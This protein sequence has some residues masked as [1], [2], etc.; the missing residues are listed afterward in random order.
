LLN[1]SQCQYDAFQAFLFTTELLGTLGVVPD[2]R[3]FKDL[4]DFG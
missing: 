4:R 3:V 1:G 2:I